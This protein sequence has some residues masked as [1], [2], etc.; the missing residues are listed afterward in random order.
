MA[1][2]FARCLD[3]ELAQLRL[4][5][6]IVGALLTLGRV[7]PSRDES[8]GDV[9]AAMDDLAWLTWNRLDSDLLF[10]RRARLWHASAAGPAWLWIGVE[11]A[12]VGY[13][14]ACAA[15]MPAERPAILHEL[16]RQGLAGEAWAAGGAESFHACAIRASRWAAASPAAGDCFPGRIMARAL[17]TRSPAAKPAT[18]WQAA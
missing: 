3:A 10:V 7:D 1:F 12:G 14:V 17:T 2:T 8:R 5:T 9:R 16:A 15:T 4:Q 18:A 13:R 6:R 11:L